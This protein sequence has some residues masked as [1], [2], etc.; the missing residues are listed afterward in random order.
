[1]IPHTD[2]SK[3]Y[4]NKTNINKTKKILTLAF[5][6]SLIFLLASCTKKEHRLTL[7]L[8]S[9]P[10]SGFE[11]EVY[12]ADKLFEVE[13]EYVAAESGKK[14]D[15]GKD[16]FTLIPIEAGFTNVTFTYK[17]GGKDK[18]DGKEQKKE[19]QDAGEGQRQQGA[20]YSY[21]IIVGEDLQI[22]VIDSTGTLGGADLGS[23]SIPVPGIE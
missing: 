8:E 15:G 17:Q 4:I 23:K 9:N 14:Q 6:L 16:H 12:Q 5:C 1:M 11:W 7:D 22:E 10:D 21:A 3:Q 2:L 18:Q 20:Q 19:G 13:K